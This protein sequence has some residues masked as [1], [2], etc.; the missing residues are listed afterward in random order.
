MITISTSLRSVREAVRTEEST[1]EEKFLLL[2]LLRDVI[3][4]TD[5]EITPLS[6]LHQETAKRREV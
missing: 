1:I 2:L 3:E 6:H 5:E 4:S